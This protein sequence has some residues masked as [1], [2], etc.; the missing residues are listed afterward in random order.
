MGETTKVL[1]SEASKTVYIGC[2]L[3]NVGDLEDIEENANSNGFI[4][5]EKELLN[6]SVEA[7]F[8]IACNS[9]AK[10]E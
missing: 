4:P 8:F 3:E 5:V 10:L 1:D 7:K 2:T 6:D 9:E